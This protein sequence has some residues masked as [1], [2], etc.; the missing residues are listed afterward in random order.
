MPPTQYSMSQDE[1]KLFCQ[2][3]KDVRLPDGVASNIHNNVHV[4]EMKLIGL[5]SHDNHVLLQ[6]LLPL[7]IRRILPTQVTA[8]LIH[9]SNFFKKIYSSTIRVS[10]MQKLEAEIA[11][12]KH[13]RNY[14]SIGIFLTLWYT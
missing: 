2:V 11:D 1:K 7:A 5:K 9:V 14:I 3:L 12:T 10:D 13:S 6:Q 4:S 8:A